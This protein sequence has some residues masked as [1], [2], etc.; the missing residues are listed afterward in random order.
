MLGLTYH[1]KDQ[2]GDR[3]FRYTKVTDQAM[4]D[5]LNRKINEEREK[6]VVV[7]APVITEV[8]KEVAKNELLGMTVSFKIDKYN[9]TD[10]QKKNVAEAA[11]YLEEH[12]E[13]NLIV[14][15]YADVQTGSPAYNLKL[16]QKRAE[17]VSNMMV[18][19]FGVDPSRIRVDYKGDSLQPYQ[20]KN[21]WNR[22]VVFITEARN[23]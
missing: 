2:Y 1:F 14:T 19:E 20:L 6:T 22:V 12:P 7:P 3:R 15:G 10:I 8:K 23:P 21:E 9:I 13:V 11:K 18:K 16:S 4:V 5:E 17:A